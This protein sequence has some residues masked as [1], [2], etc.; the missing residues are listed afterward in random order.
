MINITTDI[1]STEKDFINTLIEQT[2]KFG[3]DVFRN[4]YWN[5]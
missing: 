2:P 1:V 4:L 5:N 3:I